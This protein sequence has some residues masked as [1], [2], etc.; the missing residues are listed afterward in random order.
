LPLR[1]LRPKD[2]RG[3]NGRFGKDGGPQWVDA[4]LSHTCRDQPSVDV[5]VGPGAANYGR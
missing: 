2:S 1:D 5:C 3:A 4:C